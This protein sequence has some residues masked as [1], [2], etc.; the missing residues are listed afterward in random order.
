MRSGKRFSSKSGL[1]MVALVLAFG[2]L[3][4]A[5]LM[6]G[7]DGYYVE[8]M[9]KS[10]G[11]MGQPPSEQL[12]K[13]YMTPTKMKMIS[14]EDGEMIFDAGS[15]MLTIISHPKKE[16][17]VVAEKDFQA[18]MEM[19]MAMMEGMMGDAA[20]KVE[21][22]GEKKKIGEWDCE[23]VVMTL[24]GQMTM[25]QEMWVTKDAG[26]DM[27]AYLEMSEMIGQ[28]GLMK[29]F[30]DEMKKI[31]G[32]PILTKTTMNIMGQNVETENLVQTIRK[33]TFAASTFSAPDGYAKKEGDMMQAMQA[34][35]GGQ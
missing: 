12:T 26:I 32:Y 16:Y 35:Q 4:P 28:A 22:T 8:S 25:T 14:G 23:K 30:Q 29:K 33:E 9:V 21:A 2:L 5:A 10:G 20:P 7:D 13:M 27:D 19:G 1:S 3:S 18:M 24:S 15:K 31:D 6:A 17:Y 11:M 34:M